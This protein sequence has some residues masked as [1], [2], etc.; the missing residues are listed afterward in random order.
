MC[1][2]PPLL[3]FDTQDITYASFVVVNISILEVTLEQTRWGRPRVQPRSILRIMERPMNSIRSE[4]QDLIAVNERI[5]RAL[6]R[7]ERLT[8]SEKQII[9]LCNTTCLQ[10]LPGGRG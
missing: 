4:V 9:R 6:L 3:T 2:S 10:I 7:G 1:V 5:Q 8:D